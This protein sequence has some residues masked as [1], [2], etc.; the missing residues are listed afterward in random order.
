MYYTEVTSLFSGGFITDIVVNVP[1]RKLAKC[2]SVYCIMQ[3]W[4]RDYS[5]EPESKE[6]SIEP[7]LLTT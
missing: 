3:I 7:T 1:E 5:T 6:Y 2:T 4:Y